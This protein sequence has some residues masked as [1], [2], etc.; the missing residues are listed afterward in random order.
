MLIIADDAIRDPDR[1][2]RLSARTFHARRRMYELDP[3]QHHGWF[4]LPESALSFWPQDYLPIETLRLSRA[5]GVST[6]LELDISVYR[7]ESAMLAG[8]TNIS[9]SVERELDSRVHLRSIYQLKST[10]SKIMLLPCL[11]LQANRGDGI[12]KKSS[13][14]IAKQK[15]SADSWRAIDVA[16]AIRVNWQPPQY[17]TSLFLT[18]PGVVGDFVRKR[19]SPPLST[20]L[21]KRVGEP[22]VAD[23]KRLIDEM[24]TILPQAPSPSP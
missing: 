5:V 24:R 19:C 7:D 10:L 20:E 17:R 22:F 2:R 1:L 16:S 3:L 21:A 15:L 9:K 11:F 18:R 14:A 4:A 8:F 23:A 6:P 13:F 12:D